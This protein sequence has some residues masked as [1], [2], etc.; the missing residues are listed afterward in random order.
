MMNRQLSTGFRSWQAMAK[1]RRDA[2]VAMRRGLSFFM[3]RALASAMYRWSN[4]AALGMNNPS[5]ADA[6]LNPRTLLLHAWS[7]WLKRLILAARL[8]ITVKAGLAKTLGRHQQHAFLVWRSGF[9]KKGRFIESRSSQAK[10][11]QVVR[12]FANRKLSRGW[13]GWEAMLEERRHV[14][15]KMSKSLRYALNRNLA[16]GWVRWI[17]SREGAQRRLRAMRRSLQHMIN[18]GLS[19]GFGAWHEMAVERAE[20]MQKLRKGL[21]M[22]VNRKLALGYKTWHA[23]IAD[24]KDDPMA[25][26]LKHMMNR[27]LSRGFVCWQQMCETARAKR[28]SMR[29]SLGHLLNRQLSKGFGGWVEMTLD[30]IEFMQKLRKGASYMLNRKL[31]G[32][33]ASWRRKYTR[34]EL[35]PL[36]SGGL[37]ALAHGFRS[38][39]QLKR[40]FAWLAVRADLMRLAAAA[41]ARLRETLHDR[42][43]V[44]WEDWLESVVANVRSQQ[45]MR[46]ALSHMVNQS[47]VSGFRQLAR[48]GGLKGK[49]RQGLARLVNRQ[50]AAGWNSFA[51]F[52]V[53][54]MRSQAIARRAIRHLGNGPLA[55]AAAVAVGRIG[56]LG[57]ATPHGQGCAAHGEPQ[58]GAG[59]GLVAGHACRTGRG[60]AAPA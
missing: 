30:R 47:L 18:R 58:A 52:V 2:L 50:L 49:L 36:S 32:A 37:D 11:N 55:R 5:L 22:L 39:R 15:D 21:S 13:L 38:R 44:A 25:K 33:F 7:K 41:I 29:K 26:A 48:G 9:L 57:E 35:Q 8:E 20:F 14:R 40:A 43:H 3:D 54:R 23:R 51:E 28:E 34:H 60:A 24:K 46:R 6:S 10:I 59:H 16:K 17:E 4:K 27:G 42:L 31:G 1:E 56:R 53:Q 19:R 45:S 12:H